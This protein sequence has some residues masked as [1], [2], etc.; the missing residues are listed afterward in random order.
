MVKVNLSS[1]DKI[2]EVLQICRQYENRMNGIDA[3][4]GSYSVDACST[5]GLLALLGNIVEI[6][7]NTSDE[8]LLQKFCQEISSVGQEDYE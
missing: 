5:L 8:K 4:V 7:A 2:F 3:M 1:I 6:K